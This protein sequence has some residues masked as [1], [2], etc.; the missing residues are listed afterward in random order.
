M[1]SFNSTFGNFGGLETFV[2]SQYPYSSGVFVQ[3]QVLSQGQFTQNVPVLS[4]TL[5][6][7]TVVPMQSF[8]SHD[9]VN[10]L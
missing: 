3:P 5:Y 9:M 8:A 4:A 7:P 10:L 1:T 6:A 2:S